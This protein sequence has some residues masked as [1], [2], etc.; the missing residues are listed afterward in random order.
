MTELENDQGTEASAPADQEGDKTKR[1]PSSANTY[2]SVE[3]KT[4]EEE[5]EGNKDNFITAHDT[6]LQEQIDLA[7]EDLAGGPQA[8]EGGAAGGGPPVVEEGGPALVQPGGGPGLEHTVGSGTQPGEM[9][10]VQKTPAP[11]ILS[12]RLKFSKAGRG[13]RDVNLVPEMDETALGGDD[14]SLPGSSISE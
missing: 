10:V 14:K 1:P 7:N 11:T 5:T 12:P 6:K 3:D 2:E 8:P 13:H 4:D 9:S